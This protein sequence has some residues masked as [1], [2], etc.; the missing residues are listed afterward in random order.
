MVQTPRPN[1]DKA[2]KTQE[3]QFFFVKKRYF[4]TSY[5]KIYVE[6]FSHGL[7]LMKRK[8]GENNG[9]RPPPGVTYVSPLDQ[10]I[11]ELQYILRIYF[12]IT[13][14]LLSVNTVRSKVN[15]FISC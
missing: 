7:T 11:I 2:E 12:P 6:T 8:V 10:N 4:Y 15:T 1:I 3:N 5:A 13:H 14:N 9:F